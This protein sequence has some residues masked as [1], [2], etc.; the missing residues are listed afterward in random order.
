MQ[1]TRVRRALFGALLVV[2][3]GVAG[4]GPISPEDLLGG[5][6]GTTCYSDDEC[7][8]FNCCGDSSSARHIND[9]PSCEGVRCDEPPTIQGGC[10]IAI[11]RSNG[12][13]GVAIV[14]APGCL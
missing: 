9:G 11:C 13:C 4:C 5:P 10:G 12:Q 2:G 14:D 1:R 6:N 3:V 7:V 8:P